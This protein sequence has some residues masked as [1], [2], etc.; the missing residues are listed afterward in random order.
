MIIV[1]GV[2]VSEHSQTVIKRAIEEAERRDADLHVVHVV[3]YPVYFD[4]PIDLVAMAAAERHAVWE[5]LSPLVEAAGIPVKKVD[6]DGY[7]ADTLSDYAT[8]VGADLIVLGTRGRG[9]LASLFLG[10][11]SH[12][13]LQMA[14]C[15]ILVVR[16]LTTDS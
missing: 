3:Q 7:P 5:R 1:A 8:S 15:D 11:T 9:D 13:V 16:P 14:P 12:R 4:F 2:D 6:L 10:S